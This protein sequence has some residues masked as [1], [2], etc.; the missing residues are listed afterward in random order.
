MEIRNGTNEKSPLYGRY[1][2]GKKPPE[3]IT[4]A[5]SGLWLKFHYGYKYFTTSRIGFT[6]E[7]TGMW[8]PLLRHRTF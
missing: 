5:N 2:R 6:A 7:Y 4:L 3:T 8:H 1:C